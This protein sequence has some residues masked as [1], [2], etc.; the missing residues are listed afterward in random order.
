MSVAHLIERV[1]HTAVC[2]K[3]FDA[4]YA[5]FTN[6]LGFEVEGA[7]AE[8]KAPELAIVTGMK[9]AHI[10][11][12]MLRKG[13]HRVELFQY[14]APSGKSE[15][16]AQSDTGFTHLAFSVRDVDAVHE[17]AISEGHSPISPPQTMRG[18]IS[19]VFY[20]RGP[21]GI[22]VEFMEFADSRNA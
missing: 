1:H 20:L 18:G 3:N 22:V 19:R 8:R 11:W 13:T 12:A 14:V 21:E 9:G 5:F 6:F 16:P 17:A 4:M 2:V 7:K 10:L 15:P